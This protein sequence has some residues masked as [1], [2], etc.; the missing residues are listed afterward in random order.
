MVQP[1]SHHD[2]SS[3]PLL[4][5]LLGRNADGTREPAFIFNVLLRSVC[6]GALGEILERDRPMTLFLP[7]DRAFAEMPQEEFDRLVHSHDETW[8][9]SVLTYHV[10]PGRWPASDLMNRTVRAVNGNRVCVRQF[11]PHVRVNNSQLVKADRPA[12]NGMVH[13]IDRVL[14]PPRAEEVAA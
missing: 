9:V 5:C 3:L 6:D 10:V 11:G 7:T 12:R 1:M 13:E 4:S 2:I 8:L 14:Q